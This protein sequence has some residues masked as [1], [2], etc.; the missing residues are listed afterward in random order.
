MASTKAGP[1]S[2]NSANPI[3]ILIILVPL[4]SLEFFRNIAVRFF[5]FVFF[6]HSRF[7]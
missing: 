1:E 5:D 7:K 6:V 3:F 2:N 4:T